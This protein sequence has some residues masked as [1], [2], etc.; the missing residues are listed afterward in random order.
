MKKRTSDER[1]CV[2]TFCKTSIVAAEIN[3]RMLYGGGGSGGDDA[4]LMDSCIASF[5]VTV[6]VFLQR[7]GLIEL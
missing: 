3:T 7:C 1:S 6:L 4:Q 2:C 5:V